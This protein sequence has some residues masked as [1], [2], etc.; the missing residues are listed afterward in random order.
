MLSIDLQR[1]GL[2]TSPQ[3]PHVYLQDNWLL[4]VQVGQQQRRF[5]P[6]CSSEVLQSFCRVLLNWLSLNLVLRLK[7]SPPCKLKHSPH[8]FRQSGGLQF[9]MRLPCT[10][11]IYGC[12]LAIKVKQN[13]K[14]SK[15]FL[16]SE[17]LFSFKRISAFIFLKKKHSCISAIPGVQMLFSLFIFNHG[18]F[19]GSQCPLNSCCAQTR[20]YSDRNPK[21]MDAVLLQIAAG[22]SWKQPRRRRSTSDAEWVET[23]VIS[24]SSQGVCQ[25]SEG[26]EG[27]KEQCSCVEWRPR[28]VLHTASPRL[29]K[30][31]PSPA[32]D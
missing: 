25:G 31:R 32:A 5:G 10:E 30:L 1:R 29:C 8:C 24:A 20:F 23:C 26:C 6:V 12:T 2:S 14:S 13:I 22:A 11:R 21:H 16:T 3:M 7:E 15:T 4:R 17:Y 19:L 27:W 28:S 9:G 18:G